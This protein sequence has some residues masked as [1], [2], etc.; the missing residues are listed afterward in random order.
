MFNTITIRH[1]FY[2]V[3][4]LAKGTS[5]LLKSTEGLHRIG[6][7][8]LVTISIVLCWAFSWYTIR[9]YFWINHPEIVEVGKKADELIPK[10][11]KV[12]APYN[13]DTTFLYQTKRS[14]WPLGFDIDKK[15]AMG[16]THYVTLSPTDSD[17]ETRDL[18]NKYT[19]IVRNDKFAIIDLT[20]L[21]P[22]YKSVSK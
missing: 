19:V 18:A 1:Y 22:T 2:Y 20:V 12:I 5:F 21:N 14:G 6:S 8:A 4:F 13:G 11:A 10:N 3:W 9:T 17:L 7:I 16:A 15:I